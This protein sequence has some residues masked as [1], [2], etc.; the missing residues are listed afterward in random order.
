[1]RDG[2]EHLCL[3]LGRL[4]RLQETDRFFVQEVGP[5][6][7]KDSREE[8]GRDQRR[9]PGFESLVSLSAAASRVSIFLQNANRSFCRPPSERW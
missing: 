2:L 5:L 7:E 8:Q 6:R 9:A 4:S 3:G 1:L